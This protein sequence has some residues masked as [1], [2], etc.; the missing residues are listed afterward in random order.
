MNENRESS[1][2]EFEAS[3][4]FCN[5]CRKSQPTRKHLLLVLPGGNKFDYRCAVCGNSVGSKLDDDRSAFSILRAKT[6]D[7]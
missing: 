4:L 3:E 6:R 5:K 1:F 7:R 2:G